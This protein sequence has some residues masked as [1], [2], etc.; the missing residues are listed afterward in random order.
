MA[1]GKKKSGFIPLSVHK[2]FLIMGLQGRDGEEVCKMM[3]T[4]GRYKTA[5]E[6]IAALEA[7]PGEWVV[8]GFLRTEEEHEEYMLKTY[9]HKFK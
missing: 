9:G 1:K 5:A 7:H 6:A 4:D 3:F 8:D 2:N